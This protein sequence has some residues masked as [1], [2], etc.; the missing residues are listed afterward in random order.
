M[1]LRDDLLNPIP[2]ENPSGANLRFDPIFDK[3]KEARRVDD[4][5]NQGAWVRERK[6]AD[7]KLVIKLA[8]DT[9]ATRSKDL[10]LAAWVTEAL[11][12]QEGFAGLR[13]GLD[14]LRGLIE[15]FWDTLYPE[16]EDGDLELRASPLEWIGTRMG[17]SWEQPLSSLRK[18]PITRGGLSYY[19]FQESRTVGYEEDADQSEAKRTLRAAAVADGKVTGEDFDK[20]AAATST[21]LYEVWV[22]ALDGCAESLESLAALCEEKF[23]TY[24]PSFSPL[25]TALEEVRHTTNL[26]LQKRPDRKGAT[27][28]PEPEPE[29]QPVAS[30]SEPSAAAAA[31]ARKRTVTGLDPVDLDDVAARLDAV[32]RFLRQRN[33][34]SPGPYLMLRGY[35][36]GELRGFGETPDP[37]LLLPPTSETRQG[38]RKLALEENWAA[39]LESAETAMAQPCGRAWLDLQRYVV[40]AADA[41]G[42]GSIV[43]AIRSE[44]RTLIGDMP[45]LPTWTLMDDTPTANPETQ[46]WLKEL[47]TPPAPAPAEPAATVSYTAHDTERDTARNLAMNEPEEGSQ[48]GGEPAAP[49]TY[50]LALEAVRSGNPSE[51]VRMLAED[52]PFQPS[53]RARFQRKLQLA[54]ICMMSGHEALAQSVLEDLAVVI[55]RHSLEDWEASGVVAHPLSL[56]YRCV[57]KLDGDAATRQKL[58]SRI[59]RLDPVLALECA[60]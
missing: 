60:R 56:L 44:V 18:V 37:S 36:W 34:Y 29:A 13:Q 57:S 59:S 17:P 14:L 27:P 15:K 10:Q 30:A 51:A 25:R 16:A 48:T 1:P 11:V 28:E 23:G 9:L 32:A 4:G 49:D 54:Q 58:Y 45:K 31:P 22:A 52:I 47:A 38:I 7:Y 24:A 50:T 43:E 3:I 26:I 53:G 40:L 55:D 21:A 42:Y 20:D 2:G 41:S 39:L 8:G 33:P 35:R 19:K 46:A 5:A 6:V 12:F